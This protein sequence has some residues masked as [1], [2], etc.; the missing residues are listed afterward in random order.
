LLQCSVAVGCPQSAPVNSSQAV[1]DGYVEIHLQIYHY[2]LSGTHAACL[3][4]LFWKS[5]QFVENNCWQSPKATL[6]RVVGISLKT[7][8]K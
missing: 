8:V 6:E 7:A 5:F 3:L 1:I 2:M 4:L